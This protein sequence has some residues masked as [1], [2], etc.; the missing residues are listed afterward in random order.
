MNKRDN[1][2]EFQQ[3]LEANNIT[4]LYHFTDRDNIESIINNGGLYSWG[5]CDD[6]GIKIPKPGGSDGSKQLDARDNLEHYVRVSFTTQ[7]PMMFVAMNDG[8]ISNPVILE[9]DLDAIYWK[10]TL[11]SDRNATKNGAQK[12]VSVEDFKKIHFKTISHFIFT[13]QTK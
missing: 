1:W 9:I 3:V 6:K 11:Y 12:G 7:H 8:R 5:D 2:Q 10:N 13:W 4:K